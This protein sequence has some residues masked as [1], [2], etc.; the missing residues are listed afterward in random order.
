MAA[1]ARPPVVIIGGGIAGLTAATTLSQHGVP[2]LLLEAGKQLGGLGR[3]FVDADGFTYD[4]GA[5][6]ITN[7]LAAAIGVGGRCRTVR[8]YGETVLL[9]RE[10][11]GYPFGLLR[12]PRFARDGARALLRAALGT[13]PP[14]RNV[15]DWF[16]AAYGDALAQEVAIPIIEAWAGVPA[17]ELSPAV[18]EK[19]PSSVLR[20][21]GLKLAARLQRRAVAIGYCHD[22]PERPSV[23]HVYPEGGVELLCQRLAEGLADRVR[24]DTRVDRIYVSDG[25]ATGVR[26]D[27]VDLPA[28][29]VLSTAPVHVLGKLVEG[30]DALRHLG[31]FRYRPMI[32]VNLRLEGRGLLPDVVLWTPGVGLGARPFFRLTEAPLSMPWLAPPGKTLLTADLGCQL[33]D[34]LW[35]MAD[36]GLA[37]LC[38]EHLEEIVPGAR[39]RYLGYRVLRTPVAYPVFHNSYEAERQR[40]GRGTGI[41]G[42][43]SIGRNGE[44][45]H[46]LMEDVYWRTKEKVRRLAFRL[47][48]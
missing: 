17:T 3:S 12:T 2:F 20:T 18:G 22:L 30:S 39:R 37:E 32:F 19:L 35:R 29:A 36:A 41:G 11:H 21:I 6:F 45:A 16:R 23:W 24:L 33:D 4:F 5:H 40:L 44:F 34:A 25:R 10:L 15:A 38:L 9:G 7:R 27:G 43:Y 47:T 26:A 1:G 31:T 46:L 13:V 8:Y 48:R 28:A 14:A 42:L